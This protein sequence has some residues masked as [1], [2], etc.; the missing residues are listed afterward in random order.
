[1]AEAASRLRFRGHR[2]CTPEAEAAPLWS[3][4][5]TNRVLVVPAV[6]APEGNPGTDTQERRVAGAEAEAAATLAVTVDLES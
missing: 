3:A 6:A 5:D 4:P 2:S 1:M